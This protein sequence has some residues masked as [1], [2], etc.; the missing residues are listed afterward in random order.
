MAKDAN[1]IEGFD[2]VALILTAMQQKGARRVIRPALRAGLRPVVKGIKQAIPRR[3]PGLTKSGRK[4][5]RGSKRK[6]IP[7]AIG[8]RVGKDRN[9]QVVA[10]AG[11]KV[12]NAKI[13]EHNWFTHVLAMGSRSRY[14]RNKALSGKAGGRRT[15]KDNLGK[16]FRAFAASKSGYTGVIQ[17]E[18]FVEIGYAK[19][20]Y[21][22]RA[23]IEQRARVEIDKLIMNP[24][25]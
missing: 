23:A 17:A 11:V 10:K 7:R 12:G 14:R 1:I 20:A 18:H 25:A 5:R 19:T 3:K 13:N 22:A 9:K 8:Q 16:K 24:G 15:W 2:G 21:A 6:N 4:Q